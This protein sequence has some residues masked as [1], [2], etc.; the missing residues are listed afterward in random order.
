[1]DIVE[2]IKTHFVGSY[3]LITCPLQNEKKW[4]LI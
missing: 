3:R 4:L 1:M 2:E